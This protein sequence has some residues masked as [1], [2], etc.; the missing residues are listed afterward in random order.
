MVLFD[1]EWWRTPVILLPGGQI[2]G[3]LEPVD[4]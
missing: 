2:V 4:H 3:C 1:W